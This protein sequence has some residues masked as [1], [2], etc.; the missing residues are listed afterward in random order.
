MSLHDTHMANNSQVQVI[1]TLG[2]SMAAV[3]VF[4]ASLTFLK[5]YAIQRLTKGVTND[6]IQWVLTVPAIW[7]PAAKQL[8][9]TG[10]HSLT[11]S[12]CSLVLLIVE[13]VC[14]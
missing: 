14:E 5:D 1:D 9:R 12:L 3:Q 7:A 2:R 6:D 13:Y 11:H 4:A 8:M 10:T